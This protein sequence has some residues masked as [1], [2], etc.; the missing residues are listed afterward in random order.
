LLAAIAS[1]FAACVFMATVHPKMDVMAFESNHP[2]INPHPSRNISVTGTLPAQLQ[3][4]FFAYY[5]VDYP[6]PG[7]TG[8]ESCYRS[9]PLGPTIPLHIAQPL[10][11]VRRGSQYEVTTAVDK[12]EPGDC[13]WDLTA[14]TYR[15]LNSLDDKLRASESGWY[16]TTI[17]F[18]VQSGAGAQQNIGNKY[19]RGRVDIWCSSK[20]P[21]QDPQYPE[22]CGVLGG[23]LHDYSALIPVEER[24]SDASTAVFPDTR[25]IEIN[26]HDPNPLVNGS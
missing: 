4:E 21:I 14:V 3:I 15:V 11:I 25:S 13:G 7:E 23:F 17:A 10:T 20:A 1:G 8:H 2:Q 24:G 18:F 19:W 6:R 22:S 16:G 9:I 5:A 12:Y 26:F